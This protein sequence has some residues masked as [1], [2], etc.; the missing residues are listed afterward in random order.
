M[1]SLSGTGRIRL[2]RFAATLAAT[3]ALFASLAQAEPAKSSD[4]FVD[5]IGVNV[6]F[7]YSNYI[8][9]FD[10]VVVPRMKEIG[11]RH[12]RDGILLN[13]P[14]FVQRLAAVYAAAGAR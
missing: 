13:D 2:R 14:P 9:L 5:S 7:L 8:D 12:Y 4:A 3:S 10:T 1:T 6:H 11:L